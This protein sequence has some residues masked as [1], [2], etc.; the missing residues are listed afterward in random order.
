MT[1]DPFDEMLNFMPPEERALFR[2]M[3]RDLETTGELSA[4]TK[5]H[6]SLLAGNDLLAAVRQADQEFNAKMDRSEI[7]GILD[8]DVMELAWSRLDPAQQAKAMGHLF[9]AYRHHIRDVQEKYDL[10]VLANLDGSTFLSDDGMDL[11]LA[12]AGMVVRYAEDGRAEQEMMRT[13]EMLA[14]PL[15]N[16]PRAYVAIEAGNLWRIMQ[17][18]RLLRAKLEA[19]GATA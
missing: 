10:A 6:A 8:T 16:V 2:A 18:V 19:K 1:D 15:E 12:E 4:E 13:R 7:A 5:L 17:E 11:D 3:Q 14:L 9:T